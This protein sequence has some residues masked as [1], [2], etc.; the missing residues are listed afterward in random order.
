MCKETGLELSYCAWNRRRWKPIMKEAVYPMFMMMVMVMVMTVT[1]M[2]KCIWDV[3]W[4]GGLMVSLQYKTSRHNMEFRCLML[5]G[6]REC[7]RLAGDYTDMISRLPSNLWQEH[8][9]MCAFSYVWSLPVMWKRWRS[10]H[11]IR[12]TRKPHAACKHLCLIE[13]ELLPIEVLRCGNRN[14]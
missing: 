13:W 3:C 2:Y 14:F 7:M 4:S 5:A 1:M 12:C 9:W 11:S 10:H 6:G 8:P